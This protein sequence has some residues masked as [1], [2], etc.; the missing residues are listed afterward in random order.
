MKRLLLIVISV[1]FVL[2]CKQDGVPEGVIPKEKMLK[3]MID[4]QLSEAYLNQ[5]YKEDTLKMQ[6]HSR[7]NY[8]FNKYKIDSAQ[9]TNSLKYYSLD[10]KELDAI[11]TEASD[12]LVRL[13][14]SL[15]KEQELKDSIQRSKVFRKENFNRI[16]PQQSLQNIGF[17]DAQSSF[18]KLESINR[19][20]NPMQNTEL[21]HDISPE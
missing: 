14:E 19:S 4:M 15:Q 18:R 9:F 11:L 3:V 16:S 2:S 5:V 6:A 10:G 8:V 21:K 13:Q 17:E 1:F 12:S 20:K 7:Y